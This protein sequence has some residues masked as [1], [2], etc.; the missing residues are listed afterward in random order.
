MTA[1]VAA[2]LLLLM[3]T[4]AFGKVLPAP[5]EAPLQSIIDQ[6]APGDRIEIGAGVRQGNFVVTQPITLAGAPGAVLDGGGQ[7]TVLRVSAPGATISNLVVR[8]SGRDGAAM[9]SAIFLEETAAGATVTGNRLEGNLFGV[10]VHGAAGA[11]VRG[12][13]IA[14]LT[15]M[16][17]NEAGNGVS[18][19]NA[20]DV[21]VEGNRVTGG[22]DGIFVLASKR[23][24]FIG[25]RFEGLRY[26]IHYMYADDGEIDDNL[27]IGNDA[28]F[29]LM[30]SNNLEVR[31]NRSLHDRDYGLMFNFANR[32][33]VAENVV[34]AGP[35]AP[36]QQ[37]G[38]AAPD[39]EHAALEKEYPGIADH[40]P[41]KCLFIY[42]ANRNRFIGNWF[43]VCDVGVHFTAGSEGDVIAGNAFMGN[44][45]Q[46]KYVGTRAL[47]WSLDGRGNYWSDLAAFDL[48]GDGIADEAYR[49]NDVVDQALWRAP[50]AKLLLASPALALLR[51]AQR[52][53]PALFPGG[54]VDSY[55]LMT[56]PP[57][58]SEGEGGS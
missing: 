50:Q 54:V 18:V 6:A 4:G 47:E 34:E 26:A 52:Q 24:R 2:A 42:N 58:P 20:P 10:Y 39:S 11:V 33:R 43:Q 17:R 49:P 40:G 12:N 55:P 45:A 28:G 7:G 1:D 31:R 32:S 13:N 46:V 53:F 51:W 23:D 35:L 9:D 36:S 16:R 8:N 15:H 27:S 19:W 29:V 56:P 48:N 38:A 5:A 44:R 14:G 25:N 57:R 21:T 41:G 22:R 30:F 3:T 37:R